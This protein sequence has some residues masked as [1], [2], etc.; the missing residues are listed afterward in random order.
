MSIARTGRG[1]AAAV[2]ASAICL[3][4]A[5]ALAGQTQGAAKP[6]V[7]ITSPSAG[8]RNVLTT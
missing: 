2:V 7:S 4:P 3:A 1:L 8:I 6:S 5:A